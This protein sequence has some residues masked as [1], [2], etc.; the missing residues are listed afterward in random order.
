MKLSKT[1]KFLVSLLLIL[2]L[3]MAAFAQ[4]AE[5]KVIQKDSD[6]K[7]E[8]DKS[9]KDADVAITGSVTA[10]ELE[11]KVVPEDNVEFMGNPERITEWTSERE[12]LPDKVQP[13]VIYRDIGV[14]LKITSVFADINKIV[15]EA[16]G[17]VS[18]EKEKKPA[19]ENMSEE[20]KKPAKEKSKDKAK[21]K[22]VKTDKPK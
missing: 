22:D 4:K 9:V 18:P 1:Y 13:N 6:T 20:T 21:E 16:L 3:S 11:F 7:T 2:I 5:K 19:D 10:K 17:R 12:N 8:T 14:K 15:D